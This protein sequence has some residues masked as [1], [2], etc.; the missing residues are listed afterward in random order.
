MMFFQSFIAQASGLAGPLLRYV[1]RRW[2][3]TLIWAAAACL[4]VFFYGDAVR[5][6]RWEPLAGETRRDLACA[7]IL[8][9]WALYNVVM[10][11]RDRRTNKTM[12]D[13]L[14]KDGQPSKDDLSAQEVDKLRTRLQEAMTQLRRMV[15]GRRG[16]L[17]QLP[18]YIM[19]GPPGSGKTTALLN[20]GLKFPL[21]ETLGRDP[22]QGVGGTRNC[23]WWF[24]EEAI[25]LDTAG[26]YTTQDSDPEVDQKGWTGFLGLLK[27]YRPLQPI[28]GVIVALSI[29]DVASAN[30]Q[31][32]LAN[33]QAIRA[34]LGEL[35]RTFASRFP[36]Y[37]LLTKAD[38]LAGFVQF[39]GPG[40]TAVGTLNLV[41]VAFAVLFVGLAVDFA[42]QFTVRFREAH[43]AH[44]DVVAALGSAGRRSGGQI[45]VAALSTSAGFFAFTPTAFAGVAQLGLI[46]GTGMLIAFAC[47]L[48]IL[49]GLIALCRPAQEG[50]RVG[51]AWAGR[52]DAAI[53]RHHR[54][55]L[56][57][58][59]ALALLGAVLAP[60]LTFDG[61]PLHT[62]N[63]TSES[64]TTLADLAADPITNPYS[65]EMLEPSLA[66]IAAVSAR[67]RRL[68]TVAGTVSLNDMVPAD[69]VTRLPMI[70]DAA[71][72]L[73]PTLAVTPRPAPDAAALRAGLARALPDMQAAARTMPAQAPFALV[74]LD[75]QRLAAATDA[76]LLAADQAMTRFLPAQLHMLHTVLGAG[77]VTL[78]DIPP[79]IVG[80]WI[81]PDGRAKL[82]VL[83]T[84]AA[85]K[86]SAGLHRF[87]AQVVAA[88][89][90]AS[91]AAVA[92]VRSADTIVDAFRLAAIG[93]MAAITIILLVA[94]RRL[95]DT[96]LVVA[97]LVLSSLL[98]MLAAVLL[99]L[100]FNFANI[101]ALPLLLGVGVSFNVYFVMNWRAGIILPLASATARAVLFS[102]LTTATAFGSLALS[103]HPGTASMGRLLL[104][105][106]ACTLV[107]SLT[108]E[109]ALLAFV[110]RR[111]KA[112]LF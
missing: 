4:V 63:Q 6:G 36:I 78:A 92:I 42:I 96:A 93:A 3:R 1:R 84:R 74:T 52:A 30:P 13:A 39:F 51:F 31:E 73:G 8:A 106:L 103:T 109:P 10:L 108:F 69:Q 45:L 24:T 79:D 107:C 7:A 11:V 97:P 95:L 5:L 99:P 90:E 83:P 111:K 70:A 71:S 26:R 94:L 68:P 65:I 17:Y 101:I 102:A 12:I 76:K 86:D 66:D 49:P 47:T 21:A 98:T 18:W 50:S 14:V 44:P 33:A 25:L 35:T 60:W 91:G 88:A 89:P 105:S 2:L 16:Y 110:G 58:A 75:M 37:V 9:G 27:Q 46:A 59:A 40:R 32:R 34:R 81:T 64:V 15:G 72:I 29:E 23:D 100:P 67:L 41:S 56:A 22:L 61:D 85:A 82:Q 77:P 54:A 55:I 112:V 38:L 48:S 20:S 53:V 57:A 62:K 80:Q 87:V 19:I 43:V 104:V 28:N